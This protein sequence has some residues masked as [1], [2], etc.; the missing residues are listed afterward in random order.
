MECP[1]KTYGLFA[2]RG[3]EGVQVPGGGHAV[4]G[5]ATSSLQP[6]PARS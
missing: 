6:W 4:L 5:L 3:Q 2:G 1:T